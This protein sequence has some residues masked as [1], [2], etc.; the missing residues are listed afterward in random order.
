MTF[1]EIM[2]ILV[3][4]AVILILGVII[5]VFDKGEPRE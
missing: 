4:I 1:E 2:F 3:L 5:N